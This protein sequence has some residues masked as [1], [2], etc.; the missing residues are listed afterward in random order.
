MGTAADLELAALLH[1][2][3][4]QRLYAYLRERRE[5][6]GRDEAA[7]AAGISRSLAA[8]H[9]DRLAE[10][11]LLDVEFRRLTGRTG[12]GAGRPAKLYRLS[13]RRVEVSIPETRYAMAGH[14]LLEALEQRKHAETP[15]DTAQRVGRDHGRQVGERITAGGR[16]GDLVRRAYRVLQE[17]GFE[18]ERREGRILLRNC[19]FHE[20]MRLRREVVCAMNRGFMDGLIER[21]TGGGLVAEPEERP[22]YCCVAIRKAA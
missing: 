4:R 15:A 17:Q 10:A 13:D 3:V 8:F 21:L 9:L 18:P 2:P 12:R 7:R 6:V 19:P 5:P 11:G 20:L 16:G 14:I 22:G 1:E